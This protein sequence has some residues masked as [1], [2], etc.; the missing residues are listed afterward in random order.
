M[1]IGVEE[2]FGAVGGGGAIE[3]V[4]WRGGSWLTLEFL[5]DFLIDAVN[6]TDFH[7]GDFFSFYGFV[8]LI[9]DAFEDTFTGD[10]QTIARFLA[11]KRVEGISNNLAIE[12]AMLIQETETPVF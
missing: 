1:L 6:K 3:I 10:A 5:S 4:L 11:Q 9:N 8:A 7:G 12:I 2:K